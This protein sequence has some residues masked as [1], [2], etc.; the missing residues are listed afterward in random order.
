M[1]IETLCV[2]MSEKIAAL[3]VTYNRKQLL[4]ECIDALLKQTYEQL[5]IWIIDNASTDGTKGE[6]QQFIEQRKIVYHNTGQNLGGAGGFN[7]GIRLLAQQDYAH[8]WIM[9]DDTIPQNDALEQ[10]VLTID[11]LNGEFGFLASSVLCEDGTFCKMNNPGILRN[12]LLNQGYKNLRKGICQV[13]YASFVSILIPVKVVKE[14][15]LPIKEFFIWKDDYEY[16]TRISE[17]YTCYYSANSEVIHK[18]KS[19]MMPNIANDSKERI[20]RYF[21]E[22]RNGYYVVRRKKVKAKLFYLL[23]ILKAIKSIIT[24][25][26]N[27][28]IRRIKVV[29]CGFFAGMRFKPSVEQVK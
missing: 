12:T 24:T 15:G 13:E 17:K 25:S 10:L 8:I 21:Y 4:L 9:D 29:I 14:V 7:F 22:Y 27:Y 16:T 26:D 1:S 28:K 19:N 23:N 3:V 20:D 5:D 11:N 6:L 18:I 2:N